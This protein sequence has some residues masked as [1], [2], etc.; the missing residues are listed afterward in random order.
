MSI[1]GFVM[2]AGIILSVVLTLRLK[3]AKSGWLLFILYLLTVPFLAIVALFTEHFVLFFLILG[4][5]LLIGI[6]LFILWFCNVEEYR[7]VKTIRSRAFKLGVCAVLAVFLLYL[8]GFNG[9]ETFN[10]PS[11]FFEMKTQ[12][13]I[14]H[15]IPYR[16]E[17]TASTEYFAQ[18]MYVGLPVNSRDSSWFYISFY[19]LYYHDGELYYTYWYNEYDV[20]YSKWG[21]KLAPSYS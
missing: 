6:I 19:D 2:L 18:A 9:I 16:L 13:G 5:P 15:W 20:P 8:E 21:E 11:Q 12:I 10:R 1:W 4:L 17:Q 3:S 7:I 14:G